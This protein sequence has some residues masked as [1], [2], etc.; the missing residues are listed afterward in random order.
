MHLRIA[1][2]VT[3]HVCRWQC[4]VTMSEGG[5]LGIDSPVITMD[6]ETLLQSVSVISISYMLH[7]VPI[8][9]FLAGTVAMPVVPACYHNA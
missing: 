1:V 2:N 5:A 7:R 8:K 3:Q 9:P 6:T 4:H